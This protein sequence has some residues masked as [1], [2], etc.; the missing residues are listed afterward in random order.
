METEVAVTRSQFESLGQGLGSFKVVAGFTP[1]P[2][3][4]DPGRPEGRFEFDRPAESLNCCLEPAFLVV[5]A[6]RVEQQR[7]VVGAQVQRLLEPHGGL[8][9]PAHLLQGR[10]EGPFGS[11]T[12]RIVLGCLAEPLLGQFE[13]VRGQGNTAQQQLSTDSGG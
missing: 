1:A 7:G 6:P 13:C 10:C 8:G 2:C 3:Q 4:L 5:E 11:D 12:L 9:A